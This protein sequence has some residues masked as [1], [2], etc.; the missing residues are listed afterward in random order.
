MYYKCYLR[1]LTSVAL[2]WW[3]GM[4][5]V[6]LFQENY[7][8][9]YKGP[10]SNVIKTQIFYDPIEQSYFKYEPYPTVCPPLMKK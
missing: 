2:G 3:C 4:I 8:T 5:L 1:L 7:H 6:M 9:I 10:D